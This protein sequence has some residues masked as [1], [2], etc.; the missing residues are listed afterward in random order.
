MFSANWDNT[1]MSKQ[2]AVIDTTALIS[3]FEEV[4][5]RPAQVSEEAIKLMKC[6]FQTDEDVLLSV[7][8]IVLVEIFDK[9]VLD[10]EFRAKFVSEVLEV[11]LQRPNIEIKPI[12]DEV[13]YKFISLDDSTRNLENHDKIILASAMMLEWPLITSDS[14]LIKYVKKHKVISEV[15]T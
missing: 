11:L 5:N 2:R 8:S 1:S 3:Y 13:L 15:I 6:A 14:K 9:W 12:D 7:P 10:D 4:F